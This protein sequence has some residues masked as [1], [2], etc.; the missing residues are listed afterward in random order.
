[1]TWQEK[2]LDMSGGTVTLFATATTGLKATNS[3]LLAVSYAKVNAD[4]ITERGRLLKCV[5]DEIAME[6]LEFHKFG[7][8][9]IREIGIPPTQFISEL[10]SVLTGTCLSYNPKFQVNFLEKDM[11]EDAPYVHD[12][13]LLLKG[14]E[15][16]LCL[17]IKVLADMYT[18]EKFFIN[19]IGKTPGLRTMCQSR[20]LVAE[21]PLT[22]FPVD[23]Y[24]DCLV[25]F[26]KM[27]E[28]I[29]V[30]YQEELF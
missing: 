5:P 11:G 7:G 22:V 18:L 12:L 10:R 9:F 1:M 6:G 23:Y 28:N 27:L 14:A 20:D 30:C 8:S 19:R 25:S 29:D 13:L 4:G 2:I 17:D 3:T 15:M 26:W 24:V 16:R 21:P